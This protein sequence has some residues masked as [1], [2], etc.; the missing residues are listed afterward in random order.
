MTEE[1]IFDCVIV[2]GGPSGLTASIYLRNAGKSVAVV[3]SDIGGKIAETPEVRNIPG[4]ICISGQDF[5]DRMYEQAISCGVEFIIDKVI[6]ISMINSL[7]VV[8]GEDN[9]Y[10]SKSCIVATGTKN[11]LLNIPAINVSNGGVID[12]SIFIGNG[13]HTCSL[14][15]GIFYKDKTVAVIGGGNGALTEALYLSNI[16]KYV[17]IYQNLPNYTADTELIDR[18]ESTENIIS[19][20]NANI[21]S[22]LFDIVDGKNKF[23]GLRINGVNGSFDGVFI[24]IGVV[25]N[26][27]ILKRF[28]CTDSFGFIKV[29]E[30]MSIQNVSSGIFACGDCTNNKIK[31]VTTACGSGTIAAKSAIE[32]INKY[33]L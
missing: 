3:S 28:E 6:D 7:F 8:V 5:S 21:D 20:F 9:T 26:T 2:G 22:Y 24:S 25:P 16:C 29:N 12:E 10:V 17:Y 15:D 19:V 33:Y 27:D 11:R 13:I 4:F 23:F 14:C 30:D 32:Y 18:V 31:Q 1:R